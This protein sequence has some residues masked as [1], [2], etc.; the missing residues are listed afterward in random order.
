MLTAVA[1][2]IDIFVS[3][4]MHVVVDVT[5]HDRQSVCSTHGRMTAVFHNDWQMI[6]LLLLPVKVPQTGH[7]ATTIAILA[8]TL[9]GTYSNNVPSQHSIQ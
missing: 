8:A 6:L 2:Y 7:N 1:V 4:T 3:D 5:N 9:M